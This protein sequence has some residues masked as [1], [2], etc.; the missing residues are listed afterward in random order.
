MHRARQSGLSHLAYRVLEQIGSRVRWK[1]R[2]H[3]ETSEI[4][5]Y[6]ANAIPN[7][8]SR[9]QKELIEFGVVAAIKVPRPG[10]GRP[11]TFFTVVC[12][13]ADRANRS[14]AELYQRAV[15]DK[16]VDANHHYEGLQTITMKDCEPSPRWD[17]NHHHDGHSVNGFSVEVSD[18]NGAH[19]PDGKL[20]KEE[21][22]DRPLNGCTN[23][24]QP[25]P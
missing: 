15:A 24:H 20:F 16:V 19:A 12:S 14:V 25:L 23:P 13:A 4:I 18:L 3:S 2:Y 9:T 7:N 21:D 5:A 10:G 1:H 22:A 17:A 11:H 8:M 6:F